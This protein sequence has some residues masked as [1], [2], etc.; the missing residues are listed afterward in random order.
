ME[1][2]YDYLKNYIV[3]QPCSKPIGLRDAGGA[4]PGEWPVD[5][6]NLDDVMIG[7]AADKA[8]Y[9]SI[10]NADPVNKALGKISGWYGPFTFF[11]QYDCHQVPPDFLGVGGTLESLLIEDA[12]GGGD[13]LLE[14]ADGAGQLLLE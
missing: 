5:V 8:E 13:L 6:Y 3:Q 2:Y 11:L 9:I 4:E 14:T 10:W 7:T 12:D 1:G